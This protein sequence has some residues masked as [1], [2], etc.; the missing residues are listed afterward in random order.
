MNPVKQ[1]RVALCSINLETSA[2]SPVS[3]E[4]DFNS[5][6]YLVGEDLIAV[7]RSATAKSTRKVVGF[8]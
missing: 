4:D 5:M 1:P 2:F 7:I 8:A 6:C 3:T